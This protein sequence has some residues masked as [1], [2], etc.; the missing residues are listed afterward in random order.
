MSGFI[1]SA[2]FVSKILHYKNNWARYNQ[3]CMSVC[4]SSAVIVVRFTRNMNFLYIFSKNTPISHFNKILPV[5]DKFCHADRR[6]DMTKLTVALRNFANAPNSEGL[7][8]WPATGPVSASRRLE[9]CHLNSHLTQLTVQSYSTVW[10]AGAAL[11]WHWGCC[12]FNWW[13]DL[14]LCSFFCSQCGTL[15]FYTKLTLGMW[16]MPH[17]PLVQTVGPTNCMEQ[18]HCW[19]ANRSSA[20][21]EM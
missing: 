9:H 5:G 16:K 21:Q 13:L 2:T 4:T 8:G 1:F 20:S 7:T 12:K 18:S 11:N 3:N 6:T 17:F 14:S 19:E 10:P 15:Q